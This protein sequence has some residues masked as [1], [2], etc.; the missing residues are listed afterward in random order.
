MKIIFS[1]AIL[2]FLI[3]LSLALWGCVS[4]P[5]ETTQSSSVAVK[6]NRV[7]IATQK[8]KFKEALVSDIRNA[9]NNNSIYIKWKEHICNVSLSLFLR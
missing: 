2:S 8:T 7:L 5:L 9:L 6:K 3:F 1:V 4:P